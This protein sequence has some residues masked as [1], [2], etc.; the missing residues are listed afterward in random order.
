MGHLERRHWPD[1]PA[2]HRCTGGKRD[3]GIMS[4]PTN[5]DLEP[6]DGHLGMWGDEQRKKANL[7]AGQALCKNCG[8]TGNE[9]LFMYRACPECNGTGA[10]HAASSAG[11]KR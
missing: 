11:E 2:M 9:F 6:F 1:L 4:A 8:G 3:E 10:V 5:K 7:A